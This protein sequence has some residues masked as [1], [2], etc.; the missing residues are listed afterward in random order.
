MTY[1]TICKWFPI[2]DQA[3]INGMG[4]K[5][6][7][8]IFLRHMFIFLAFPKSWLFFLVKYGKALLSLKTGDKKQYKTHLSDIYNTDVYHINKWISKDIAG[9]FLY[10]SQPYSNCTLHLLNKMNLK[11]TNCQQMTSGEPNQQWIDPTHKYGVHFPG[12]IYLIPQ[13]YVP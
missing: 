7:K 3:M 11:K 12:L 13:W 6:K 4:N 9:R 10:F 8:N 1:W 2:W 5:N